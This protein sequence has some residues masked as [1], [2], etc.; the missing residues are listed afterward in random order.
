MNSG[1]TWVRTFLRKTSTRAVLVVLALMLAGLWYVRPRHPILLGSGEPMKAIVYRE[2]GLAD[3]LRYEVTEKPLPND[4][5][6]VR[7]GGHRCVQHWR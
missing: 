1:K 5:Q 6:S 2:Y 7:C 3:V 4:C